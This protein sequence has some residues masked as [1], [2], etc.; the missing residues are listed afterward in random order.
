MVSN[1]DDDDDDDDD[2][3]SHEK[4]VIMA[5]EEMGI[6]SHTYHKLKYAFAVRIG[7]SLASGASSSVA[8]AE[9]SLFFIKLLHLPFF[10]FLF[11]NYAR[12]RV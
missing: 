6:V 7:S 4:D 5:M 8:R 9:T 1:T 3:E 2:V 11:F 12:V 10:V